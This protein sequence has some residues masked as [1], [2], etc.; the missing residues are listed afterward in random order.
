MSYFETVLTE[1]GHNE[2]PKNPCQLLDFQY[3]NLEA[4]QSYQGKQR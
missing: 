1:S 2:L 4:G 3:L